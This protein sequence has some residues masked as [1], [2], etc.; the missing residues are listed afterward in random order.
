LVVPPNDTSEIDFVLKALGEGRV[1][2]ITR[3]FVTR[4]DSIE[5]WH[6]WPQ[7][8]YSRPES[9]TADRDTL[10]QSD[11][12]HVYNVGITLKTPEQK[13]AA[14]KILGFAPE[15]DQFG[16][17]GVRITLRKLYEL[18]EAGVPCESLTKD[19]TPS[20][21]G[22]D[23][24]Q[25]MQMIG[26]LGMASDDAKKEIMKRREQTPLLDKNTEAYY[27]DG[28]MW[29]RIYGETEFRKI[30]PITDVDTFLR[31]MNDSI[32][33][34]PPDH[35]F[36][37]CLMLTD[38]KEISQAISIAGNLPGPVDS[39]YY[40]VELTRRQITEL[41]KSKI[42]FSYIMNGRCVHDSLSGVGGHSG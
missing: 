8:A 42:R 38:D 12:D 16:R 35:L 32:Q 28:E 2:T 19:D 37:I 30:T 33:A 26:P 1:V 13:A 4:G 23:N 3:V 6:G 20:F 24:S 27:I 9:D 22:L 10:K 39:V 21:N 36:D 11:L 17:A 18:D 14:L 7:K 31:Q 5:Y 41:A 29:Q 40:H 34:L 15:T 25:Q